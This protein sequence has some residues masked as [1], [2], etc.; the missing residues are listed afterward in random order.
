MLVFGL[1]LLVFIGILVA[2][3][4]DFTNGWHDSANAIATV[5]ATKVLSPLQA[6]SMAAFFNFVGPFLFTLAVANTVGKGIIDTKAVTPV[7]VLAALVGAIAWNIATWYF[8]LPSSSSHALVGG[9]VGAALAAAGV[10][11]VLLPTGSEGL[12]IVRYGVYGAAVGVG[13][14]ALAWLWSR[15]HVPRVGYPVFA[16]AGLVG[17]VWLG[18]GGIRT[19]AR[20]LDTVHVFDLALPVPARGVFDVGLIVLSFALMGAV[21]GALLWV[22]SQQKMTPSNIVAFA[23]SGGAISLILATLLK[24]GA[25]ATMSGFT[26]TVLFM[27]ISPTLGFLAGFVLASIVSWAA[28][29]SSPSRVDHVSRRAQLGSSAFY[30]LT[31]GTNDA[32]KTM[33]VIAVL[34]FSTG[35]LGASFFVPTWVI[36]ASALSMGLGTLFG[37]WRIVHTLANRI[38]ALRPYQG[39]AAETGGGVVLVA[40][41]S[42][43]IPVSTTHAISGSIMGVGATR[44]ASAVRWGTGRRIVAAWIITI[45]AAA[46]VAAAAYLVLHG[47]GL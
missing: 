44:R 19:P 10:Q 12:A 39:F 22:M 37:G 31:H 23:F 40:M 47:F 6:V 38:T 46:L 16:A 2:L 34:L 17:M 3:L 5:V 8:G 32:Q 24:W 26:K 20:W 42:A 43:G 7:L 28:K 45:P 35:A 41:A 25:F 18:R 11:S 1:S 30:A 15:V 36:L 4:F 13:V 33:G 14:G 27:V 9:L 29:G 21:V